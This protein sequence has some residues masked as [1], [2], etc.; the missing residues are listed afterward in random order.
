[1]QLQVRFPD[2][3]TGFRYAAVANGRPPDPGDSPWFPLESP[4][5][6]WHIRHVPDR[7]PRNGVAVFSEPEAP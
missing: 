4:L 5:A 3:N 2:T 1:M 6:L 7:D